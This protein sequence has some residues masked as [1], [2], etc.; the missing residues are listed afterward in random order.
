MRREPRESPA[1]VLGD[2]CIGRFGKALEQVDD[3]VVPFGERSASSGISESDA[4]VADEP[5]PFR[6]LDGAAAEIL[7]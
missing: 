6:A 7:R 2:D 4:S 3:S 1:R 5:A